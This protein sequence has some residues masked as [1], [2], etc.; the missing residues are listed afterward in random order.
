MQIM[1]HNFEYLSTV[2]LILTVDFIMFIM[3][4]VLYAE[5]INKYTR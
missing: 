2:N 3:Y 1:L 5:E 4:H